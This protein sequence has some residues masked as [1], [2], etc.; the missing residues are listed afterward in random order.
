MYLPTLSPS[1]RERYDYAQGNLGSGVHGFTLETIEENVE[2]ADT[3]YQSR[4]Y[5]SPSELE[6]YF[7]DQDE[8]KV[9]NDKITDAFESITILFEKHT[10]KITKETFA[11]IAGEFRSMVEDNY[12]RRNF[13][14][15]I[16]NF[17]SN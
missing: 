14:H 2:L 1:E 12:D 5:F 13:E 7:D 11:A 6:T 3:M 8:L 10:G 15:N 16:R 17:L 4:K 9:Q